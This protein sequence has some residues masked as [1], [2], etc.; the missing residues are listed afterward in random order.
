MTSCALRATEAHS[1][2][3][4]GLGGQ[5]DGLLLPRHHR[6]RSGATHLLFERFI[7]KERDEPPDIDV[8]FEHERREEVMQ[9]IYRRYGRARAGLTAI[10]RHLSHPLGASAMSARSSAFRKCDRALYRVRLWG[11]LFGRSA[12]KEIR[13]LG[14]DPHEARLAQ[15]LRSPGAHRFSAPSFAAYGRLRHHPHAAR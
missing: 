14:F 7:S 4:A 11:W 5:F 9:Y 1:L 2:P 13:R 10:G 15:P 6:C 12:G 8:D 3:G